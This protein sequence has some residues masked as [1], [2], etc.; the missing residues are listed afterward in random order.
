VPIA[1]ITLL[2]IVLGTALLYRTEQSANE[3]RILI[4]DVSNEVNDATT[5]GSTSPD[6]AASSVQPV[7]VPSAPDASM[8]RPAGG[9]SLVAQG[10]SGRAAATTQHLPWW[11]RITVSRTS[12]IADPR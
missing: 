3:A 12:R 6:V 9:R 8:T 1:G 7:A 11:R 5:P 2:A 10:N 4:P